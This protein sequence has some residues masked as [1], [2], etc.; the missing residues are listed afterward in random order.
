[1][2]LSGAQPAP[3]RGNLWL[4]VRDEQKVMRHTLAA[5][6]MFE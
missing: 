5:I 4:R 6:R 1:L 2:A 3:Q